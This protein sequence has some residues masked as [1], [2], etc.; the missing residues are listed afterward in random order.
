[1]QFFLM[2]IPHILNISV[3]LKFVQ[4]APIGLFVTAI[5]RQI[6]NAPKIDLLCE[7]FNVI[8][9]NKLLFNLKHTYTV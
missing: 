7:M 4:K 5:V 2:C 1:M 3:S 9:S 6:H 8:L